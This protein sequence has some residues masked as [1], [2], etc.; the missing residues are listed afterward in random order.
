[1]AACE[2]CLKYTIFSCL[3]Q[4]ISAYLVPY[5]LGGTTIMIDASELPAM[6]SPLLKHVMRGL[7]QRL[8][9]PGVSSMVHTIQPASR[10]VKLPPPEPLDIGV[11]NYK[12]R[13]GLP[14]MSNPDTGVS[15]ERYTHPF[16]QW[17]TPPVMSNGFQM[18]EDGLVHLD[19]INRDFD[20]NRIDAA[21][22]RDSQASEMN[23]YNKLNMPTTES[24]P[25]LNPLTV[26]PV[27]HGSTGTV[28]VNNE[29]SGVSVKHLITGHL[30]PAVAEGLI[31]MHVNPE[32]VFEKFDQ[33]RKDHDNM[34][35]D[36]G[37]EVGAFTDTLK[38]KDSDSLT[39]KHDLQSSSLPEN[40]QLLREDNNSTVD[41]IQKRFA[42]YSTDSDI[43][44]DL[45]SMPGNTMSG[46]GLRQMEPSISTDDTRI[47]S[48][49]SSDFRSSDIG[50]DSR[51]TSD[52][53]INRKLS[54]F[55]RVFVEPD[56]TTFVS[57]DD[58]SPNVAAE[59]SKRPRRPMSS[60]HQ[61]AVKALEQLRLKNNIQNIVKTLSSDAADA[62]FGQQS[63]R[64]QSQNTDS[65]TT[66]NLGGDSSMTASRP[67]LF[68]SLVKNS[69]LGNLASFALIKSSAANSGPTLEKL[70]PILALTLNDVQNSKV[71]AFHGTKDASHVGVVPPNDALGTSST[72]L[73]G[74]AAHTAAQAPAL[75]GDME[76]VTPGE[77]SADYSQL[78]IN[79]GGSL[80]AATEDIFRK[81]SC[82]CGIQLSR[83][84]VGGDVT[85]ISEFP[86]MVGL[87]SSKT[88]FVF[89]G[90]SLITDRHV[91]TAAHCVYN[92]A[93]DPSTMYVRG[94]I[95]DRD[96][97]T[98]VPIRMEIKAIRVHTKY[99]E[100]DTEYDI[101]I[102]ALQSPVQF[103]AKLLPVCLPTDPEPA[104]VFASGVVAGW[105]RT[106]DLGNFPKTL[107]KA[108][109]DLM[110]SQECRKNSDY[111]SNSITNRIICARSPGKDACQGDSGGPLMVNKDGAIEA[112]GIVSWG[113]GCADERY[114]G[115]Y[116]KIYSYRTWIKAMTIT[117]TQ[118]RADRV[119]VRIETHDAGE[120]RDHNIFNIQATDSVGLRTAVRSGERF[121][122]RYRIQLEPED[123]F[124][125][126]TSSQADQ[127]YASESR[128]ILEE[129]R[130]AEL[131][132]LETSDDLIRTDQQN[133][134]SHL[135][136]KETPTEE[137]DVIS[138]QS[139][140]GLP[141]EGHFHFSAKH[142]SAENAR[143]FPGKEKKGDDGILL[144]E[145]EE[146]S[147][148]VSTSRAGIVYDDDD[149]L[150]DVLKL[151]NDELNEDEE[152]SILETLVPT[153]E[154]NNDEDFEDP[155]E[156]RSPVEISNDVKVLEKHTGTGFNLQLDATANPPTSNTPVD[157]TTPADEEVY[158]L[159]TTESPDYDKITSLVQSESFTSSSI[160]ESRVQEVSTA[161]RHSEDHT[162]VSRVPE[163]ETSTVIEHDVNNSSNDQ[164][165]SKRMSTFIQGHKEN[166]AAAE[167]EAN[168]V[169]LDKVKLMSNQETQN[170]FNIE[171]D[172]GGDQDGVDRI[173][174]DLV[175]VA[176]EVTDAPSVQVKAGQQTF[177]QS[178]NHSSSDSS[179]ITIFDVLG[180]AV[181]ASGNKTRQGIDE[182]EA[183]VQNLGPDKLYFETGFDSN[184][185]IKD[186]AAL[187]KQD[188]RL[189]ELTTTDGRQIKY[190]NEMNG[191]K[192]PVRLASSSDQIEN[193]DG[194]LALAL[195]DL[196]EEFLPSRTRVSGKNGSSDKSG[197][198]NNTLK[199]GEY[200]IQITRPNFLN[201]SSNFYN[202]SRI[203]AELDEEQTSATN[204]IVGEGNVQRNVSHLDIEDSVNSKSIYNS[205]ISSRDAPSNDSYIILKNFIIGRPGYNFI[206]NFQ[207]IDNKTTSV[208]TE[209]PQPT[210]DG[211]IT[212]VLRNFTIGRPGYNF[213]LDFDD[214]DNITASE[215][216]EQHVQDSGVLSSIVLKN[217]TIG[218]PGYNF[219]LDF[220]DIG[221]TTSS[222]WTKQTDTNFDGISANETEKVT[223]EWSAH[224]FTAGF[225]GIDNTTEKAPYE[226]PGNNS[227]EM[228]TIILKKFTIGRPGYNFSLDFSDIENTTAS[229]LA[230]QIRG[231]SN[232]DI[233]LVL[234]NLTIGHNFTQDL[235]DLTPSSSDA[236]G[237]FHEEAKIG[238]SQNES[239]IDRHADKVIGEKGKIP[240]IRQK[241]A[242]IRDNMILLF[243]RDAG[244][245]L[246]FKEYHSKLFSSNKDDNSTLPR[247]S[248]A[249]VNPN[250]HS[251]EEKENSVGVSKVDGLTDEI[252]GSE[253][254]NKT[255][256]KEAS[257][258]ENTR[259]SSN[260]SATQHTM[261]NVE[262]LRTIQKRIASIQSQEKP[263]EDDSLFGILQRNFLQTLSSA[264]TP[265]RRINDKMRS[266][267][268]PEDDL[269]DA[270]AKIF[271]HDADYNE[272]TDHIR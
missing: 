154:S 38:P 100:F 175:S 61:E 109:V 97:G 106:E 49:P 172:F 127:M 229:T 244:P 225:F 17:D 42:D 46:T 189:V 240:I 80:H 228:L 195:L 140:D 58:A 226:P 35:S 41:S 170:R 77:S 247:D 139:N 239:L 79:I 62:T 156:Q 149:D 188:E 251:E 81:D 113:V 126:S 221:N 72:M 266:Q 63:D 59:L 192:G 161:E 135:N 155:I 50:T 236:T 23:S 137:K 119:A 111:S 101:A 183:L 89:C 128:V 193:F 142:A 56:S 18:T 64:F 104:D 238:G 30:N 265:R 78:L 65:D 105:G 98:D 40:E 242:K 177:G 103:S 174:E 210:S 216:S 259:K 69:N 122:H 194:N 91:I 131:K 28:H 217:F 211:V 16:E 199:L 32:P 86:W 144:T 215:L 67:N 241:G 182:I 220:D 168:H 99:S 94:G 4:L 45:L 212:I 180:Q 2:T 130:V 190:A 31:E 231:N 204:N 68:T 83:K 167:N 235:D 191:K 256:T 243:T 51:P 214:I 37:A 206:F 209:K 121:N 147:P 29:Y 124:Y 203:N 95:G 22:M 150:A 227:A 233:T 85:K 11:N 269:N 165:S 262:R 207:D 132:P 264:T 10:P 186:N 19:I 7:D 255:S 267:M 96:D 162:E 187:S 152:I 120:R 234:R 205:E 110:T 12:F 224:N 143:Q 52:A 123:Y 36:V 153:F 14:D 198:E 176:G 263:E 107:Q 272:E 173:V 112:I 87:A 6:P 33:T 26:K 92:Y 201:L 75:A 200:V 246:L 160:S 138:I 90:G 53:F 1:M 248:N 57:G 202:N 13:T 223:S 129:Q 250:K 60:T 222:E 74:N 261:G 125:D 196:Q 88:N 9:E 164:N 258:G 39:R 157:Y 133:I 208:P 146:V 55:E 230:E 3:A 252:A 237:L 181:T 184:F 260:T 27:I 43:V 171:S 141:D 213:T 102:I 268:K 218:K 271:S 115:I 163:P 169:K 71:N 245:D 254:V 232:S 93:L 20:T 159:N 136:F 8:E 117:G 249:T 158:N 54:A 34:T 148:Y 47:K 219:S 114:P 70:T 82:R 178:Y 21:S 108:N 185:D 25:D 44:S 270:L 66:S 84:I 257:K 48:I 179:L 166:R 76:Q 116:T 73:Q 5:T 253:T 145:G 197:T 134:S 24:P 118:C 151:L 15:H